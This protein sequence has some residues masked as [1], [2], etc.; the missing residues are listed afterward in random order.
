MPVKNINIKEFSFSAVFL[1]SFTLLLL[2]KIMLA[3][4]LDLYSDE[5]F[6]WQASTIPAI[7]YSDLPFITAFLV[8]I[9]AS[10]D[11]HNP[12]AV[13]AVFILIG[14]SIPFLIYWLALPITNKKEA[15]QSAFLT[16]CLPLLGFLGLLA[17][18]DAPLIFFGILSI[19]FFERAIRTN[20]TKFWIATGVF[21]ALGLSTHYRFLV[22]PASA[23]LFLIAFSPARK[24]W[25]NPRLW[26]CIATA[27]VGLMPILWF[28][29]SYSF[30]SAAFYF[31]D[32]HPWEFNSTGLLHIF[33]QALVSSP[34]MYLLFLTTIYLMIGKV[35][36]HSLPAALLLSFSLTNL[37]IYAL[38]APWSDS[39]STTLHWPLSG[40]VP[41]LV[42]LPESLRLIYN[43]FSN[44][45]K[46]RAAKLLVALIPAI[47]LCGTFGILL[48]IGS[49]A[50]Q[51]PLQ[52]IFG[53]EI[54]ST[55]MAGWKQFTEHTRQLIIEKNLSSF[56]TIVTDNYYTAA[57]LE[58]AGIKGNIYTIDKSKAL[59]DGR[60]RQ[61]QIWDK[62]QNGLIQQVQ[63]PALFITEDSVL[64]ILEKHKVIEEMC[65]YSDELV[66]ISE[67]PLFDRAKTFSY[68]STTNLLD[69]E[70]KLTNNA[71]CPVPPRAWID[72]PKANAILS[73]KVTVA[74][75]AY[76]EHIGIESIEV[77]LDGQVVAKANYGLSRSDVVSAMN[78]QTDPNAPNLGFEAE[79]DTTQIGNGNHW[80]E[81]MLINSQGNSLPYKK[82]LLK[83]DNP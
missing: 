27:S 72:T 78:V 55:K 70:L 36:T 3:S 6:Y 15:L 22:Y 74:G 79:I 69:P 54:L 39:N 40:Y 42:F 8:G 51:T 62:H 46:K 32:R 57:Q 65:M 13:R 5:I 61:Y 31:V 60:L 23:I 41:L 45:R 35:R 29:F 26:L 9:G 81:L 80:L 28:N 14:S 52:K 33:E 30:E 47:G 71:P 12:L 7:A 53:E 49:Q 76:N 2:L 73:G 50:F 82:S 63:K 21:V 25:K 56:P 17:V 75:W 58:F 20:L 11:S 83:I 64:S 18:P 68:Y 37:I 19:G 16:L 4:I 1:I 38:L 24:H 34:P 10:L 59:Q 77:M 43:W 67:L 44:A 48:G 66:F